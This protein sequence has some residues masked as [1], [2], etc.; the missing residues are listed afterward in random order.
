MIALATVFWPWYA[1]LVRAQVL[2]I[3]ERD[4]VDAR[5]QHRPLRPGA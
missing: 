3:R 5:P 1:R 2:S 4:Y